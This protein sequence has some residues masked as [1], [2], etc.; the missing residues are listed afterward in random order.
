MERLAG[1]GSDILSWFARLTSRLLDFAEE[2]QVSTA[3]A[4]SP[5]ALEHEAALQARPARASEKVIL[6]IVMVDPDP[7]VEFTTRTSQ[8]TK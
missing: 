7:D 3:A 8:G 5:T 6:M 1:L 2:H 4:C